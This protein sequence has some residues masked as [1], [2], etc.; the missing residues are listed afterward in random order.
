M[1]PIAINLF[2]FDRDYSDYQSV[3]CNRLQVTLIRF[4]PIQYSL[5]RKLSGV[6]MLLVKLKAKVN[7]RALFN[8]VAEMYEKDDGL[9]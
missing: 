4:S 8:T 6:F 5:H 3:N 7:C 2:D 1:I 9:S